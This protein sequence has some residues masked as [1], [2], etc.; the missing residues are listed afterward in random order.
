MRHKKSWLFQLVGVLVLA[1]GLRLPLLN[2][3]FWLDEAAQVLESSRP[4]SQQLDIAADFQPPLIHLLTHVMVKI[5]PQEWWLRTWAALIP[6]LL[7]IVLTYLIGKKIHSHQVGLLAS[8]LLATSS[9]HIFYSQELRP[10]ALPLLWTTLSWWLLLQWL[11]TKKRPHLAWFTVSTVLGLY[12]S[13]L[14]PFLI[15]SQV[16]WVI[17]HHR[18]HAKQFLVSLVISALAFGPWLPMFV[19]Q[20]QVGGLLRTQ[21]P[22][23]ETVVSTPQ[24]KTLALTFG[25]FIF[26]VLNIELNPLYIG[27]C[28]VIGGLTSFLALQ[29]AQGLAKPKKTLLLLTTW[30]TIPFATSW[31][32]SFWVP[33]VQPKRLLYLLPAFYLG[34][35]VVAKSQ[36]NQAY[37]KWGGLLVSLLLILNCVSTLS[38]YLNPNLQRENWRGLHAEITTNFTKNNSIA[39]FAF[40]EPFAPWIWYDDGSFPTWASDTINIQ[41]NTD[42]T[43]QLSVVT[44][45]EYV[46]LFEYLRDLT[47]PQDQ[48]RHELWSLG[49]TEVSTIDYP[50]IGFVRVYSRQKP[51]ASFN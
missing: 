28:V 21:L 51:V 24:L 5:S 1:L 11:D 29:L 38:Y 34:V 4:F 39:V 47:D 9:F 37:K 26:G 7:S 22:S 18:Q 23:W 31:F 45:Y 32:I 27:L 30:L 15:M 35:T 2:G 25:K 17:W 36:R 46:L 33:V 19:K 48:L 8:L 43:K 41:D 20:L 12:S 50:N 40:H 16:V 10:Y 6:G 44:E 14:Y 42:L 3:S 49:Y 13:Y